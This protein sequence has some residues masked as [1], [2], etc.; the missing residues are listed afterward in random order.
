M[1]T[2]LQKPQRKKTTKKRQL[3]KLPASLPNYK[4][5]AFSYKDIQRAASYFQAE[6][7]KIEKLI[8]KVTQINKP[9]S[10]R[11][12]STVNTPNFYNAAFTQATN[13]ASYLDLPPQ[14]PRVFPAGTGINPYQPGI[15]GATLDMPT[16][17]GGITPKAE[18]YE[19]LQQP[20]IVDNSAD[21]ESELKDMLN[22]NAN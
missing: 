21:L 4:Y 8:G 14:P 5:E 6:L 17:G 7:A 3:N 15:A 13:P 1:T 11:Y 2:P 18:V 20:A 12:G 19:T 10:V 22:Q 16:V 9:E